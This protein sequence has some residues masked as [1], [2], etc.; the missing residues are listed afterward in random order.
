MNRIVLALCEGASGAND[1]ILDER[2]FSEVD[3]VVETE[4]PGLHEDTAE[5]IHYL[6]SWI[7]D[8][9]VDLTS[10]RLS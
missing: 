10:V 5:A 3:D 1:H 6:R 8:G 9:L 7:L 2:M 4:R